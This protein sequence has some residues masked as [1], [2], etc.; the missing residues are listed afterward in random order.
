MMAE[1]AAQIALALSKSESVETD[2]MI[3]SPTLV[4]R[5]SVA[6]KN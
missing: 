4:Q 2:P 3:Y 1:K 5:A 6:R